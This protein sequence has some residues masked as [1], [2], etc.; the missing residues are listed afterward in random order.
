VV[1][2]F[3]LLLLRP[4]GDR[5]AVDVKPVQDQV[6][7][8][9]EK[10]LAGLPAAKAIAAYAPKMALSIAR[11]RA[12]DWRKK[13]IADLPGAIEY[14]RGSVEGFGIPGRGKGIPEE[15]LAE[16]LDIELA[17]LAA[18]VD[19]ASRRVLTPERR[20]EMEAQIDRLMDAAARRLLDLA[21]DGP[22][23]GQTGKSFRNLTQVWKLSI[24]SPYHCNLDR[25][26]TEPELE[27]VLAAIRKAGE[28]R[29]G[30]W[31]FANHEVRETVYLASQRCFAEYK[32]HSEK[33]KA[34]QDKR[35]A[36]DLK[37][38]ENFAPEEK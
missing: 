20:R 2:V 8:H 34:W 35:R 15:M 17:Y 30:D 37:S 31:A 12:E 32:P 13:L 7:Q 19:R 5:P 16:G 3:C 21:G 23:P 4:D 38:L 25:P 28:T 9:L 6:V 26:L 36:L 27:A 24:G 14:H 33:S 18:S 1:V 11:V 10:G 29:R 22:E